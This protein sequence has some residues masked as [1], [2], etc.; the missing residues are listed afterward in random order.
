MSVLRGLAC[1]EQSAQRKVGVAQYGNVSA[2]PARHSIQQQAG[3]YTA[4]LTGRGWAD[5]LT[6]FHR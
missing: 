1:D 3:P 5:A 4:A 2:C 6:A